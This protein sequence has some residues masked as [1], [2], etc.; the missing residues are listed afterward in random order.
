MTNGMK[1]K[2]YV[3]FDWDGTLATIQGDRRY[4]LFVGILELLASLVEKQYSLYLWTARDRYSMVKIMEELSVKS[5]FDD[6]RTATDCAPKPS[7]EGLGQMLSG[8]DKKKIVV[9]GDSYADMIGA[10]NFGAFALGAGWNPELNE[11]TLREFQ[12]DDIPKTPQECL[13]MIESLI[14]DN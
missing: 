11:A 4:H 3:V 6:I 7:S 14:K 5:F 1:T 10:K 12:V 9:V 8:I 13:K 2:G